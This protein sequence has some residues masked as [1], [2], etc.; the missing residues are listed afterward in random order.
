MGIGEIV[1]P[2][3]EIMRKTAPTTLSGGAA[4]ACFMRE[5][6]L[7]ASLWGCNLDNLDIADVSLRLFIDYLAALA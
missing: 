1:E 5:Y 7:A 6:D 2:L 4:F 3:A